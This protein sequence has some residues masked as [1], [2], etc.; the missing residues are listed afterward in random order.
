MQTKHPHI[1]R[2]R[3]I[4]T[5][6]GHMFS[7]ITAFQRLSSCGRASEISQPTA[8][9]WDVPSSGVTCT[10]MEAESLRS[11]V[12]H[13]YLPAFRGPLAEM[14][15]VTSVDLVSSLDRRDTST[16][17]RWLFRTA[18]L[19]RYQLTPR[20]S[21]R[22]PVT[23]HSSLMGSPSRT[24]SVPDTWIADTQKHH[25]LVRISASFTFQ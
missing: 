24:D 25:V 11:A 2:D 16:P 1:D 10:K 21:T 15:S 3:N 7:Y 18:E 13:V 20:D 4:N 9:R 6:S 14:R 23:L 17:A 8:Y 22:L 5:S 12:R 19:P